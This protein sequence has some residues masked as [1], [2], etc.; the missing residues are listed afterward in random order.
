MESE[1]LY[2]RQLCG[3]YSFS[4]AYQD[5]FVRVMTN[6]KTEGS[7]VE[8]GAGHPVEAN[9]TY[10]LERD[11][12][13]VGVSLEVNPDLCS[14]FSGVRRNPCFQGDATN[15]DFESIFVSNNL[16]RQIDYLSL[17]IEPASVTLQALKNLPLK[18][19][20]FSVITYEHDFY[21]DGPN[22]MHEAREILSN[23]NYKRVASN[24][25]SFGRDFEDW[26]VDP[27]IIGETTYSPFL[28]QGKECEELFACLALKSNE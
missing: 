3:K 13:W 22:A 20:R 4:Q 18:T 9:N 7:Y 21:T 25:K 26:Y 12:Q 19:F 10:I 11:L 16:P 1:A 6:F 15:V 5:L 14:A 24:V 28:S 2:K 17:D 8:I 27:N 23:F